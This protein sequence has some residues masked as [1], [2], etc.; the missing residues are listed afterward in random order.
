MLLLIIVSTALA[1]VVSNVIELTDENCHTIQTGEWFIKAY[2]P[3]CG[4]SQSIATP[5]IKLGEWALDK[6]YNI[7]EIDISAESLFGNQLLVKKTPALFHVKDG[8]FTQFQGIINSNQYR[9]KVDTWTTFL[10]EDMSEQLEPLAWYKRPGS[11]TMIL[12]THL[13]VKF[14]IPAEATILILS[15]AFSM[16]AIALFS[17]SL[18]LVKT[19]FCKLELSGKDQ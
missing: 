11:T 19:K 16:I 10:K 3:N 9:G 7:A 17:V 2:A 8:V 4:A 14:K 1:V 18:K 6:D 13:T 12:Y 5:W 15:V